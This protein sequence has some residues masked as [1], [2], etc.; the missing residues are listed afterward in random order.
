MMRSTLLF[1]AAALLVGA[2]DSAR[3]TDDAGPAKTGLIRVYVSDAKGA[4]VAADAATVTVELDYGG[5]KKSLETERKSWKASAEPAAEK[6]DDGKPKAPRSHGGQTVTKDGYV[7]EMVVEPLDEPPYGIGSWFEATAPFVAYQ[8]G[9][10]DAAPVEEPGK[11][12]SC[13][14]TLVAQDASFT[15]VVVVKFKDRS[16]TAP[17]FAYP[18]A[19]APKTFDAATAE[20]SSRLDEIDKL[21]AAG[22]LAEIRAPAA[23]FAATTRLLDRLAP[24]AAR[25]KVVGYR[26]GLV[27][28]WSGIDLLVDAGKADELKR[29]LGLVRAVLADLKKA[30]N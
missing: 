10:K 18:P 3:A 20:L 16:I 26:R 28:L 5:F 4:A 15:G 14:M 29:L 21:L 27:M 12:K 9:M 25:S 19:D 13:G 30:A 1:V 7:I 8:D 24:A 17:G 22:T 11:C 6:K 2:A 23:K